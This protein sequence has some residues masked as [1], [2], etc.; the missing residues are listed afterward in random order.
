MSNIK[1]I[2]REPRNHD[3]IQLLESTLA[4]VKD[5]PNVTEAL[6]FIKIDGDYHRMSSGVTD[7]MQLVAMLELAKHDALC[8]MRE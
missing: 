6:V 2:K 4:K 7:M 1:E 5:N 8:R 3:V